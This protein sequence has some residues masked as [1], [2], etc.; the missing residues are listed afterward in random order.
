[1]SELHV[2]RIGIAYVFV[3]FFLVGVFCFGGLILLV[4][5]VFRLKRSSRRFIRGESLHNLDW[6]LRTAIVKIFKSS[7]L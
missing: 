1:M 2:L 6:T 4:R 7:V 3:G 5:E